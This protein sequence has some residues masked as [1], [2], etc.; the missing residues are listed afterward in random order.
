MQTFFKINYI[1]QPIQ[2]AL[3]RGGVC[4]R[5]E[6]AALTAWNAFLS[7]VGVCFQFTETR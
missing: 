1:F 6:Y 2:F 4:T 7:D 3:L 5:V